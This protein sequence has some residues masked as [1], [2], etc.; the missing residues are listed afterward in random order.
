MGYAV[1]ALAR[2]GVSVLAQRSFDAF[3]FD[4]WSVVAYVAG[5]PGFQLAGATAFASVAM[6][7]RGAATGD[8]AHL[9]VAAL[10]GAVALY[11]NLPAVWRDGR[12]RAAPRPLARRHKSM[13]GRLPRAARRLG[14]VR[15]AVAGPRAASVSLH[16]HGDLGDRAPFALLAAF[17][18]CGGGGR[19]RRRRA[20]VGVSFFCVFS[21]VRYT[22]HLS[23]IVWL[24]SSVPSSHRS[25][26]DVP[27]LRVCASD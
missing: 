24:V 11:V 1:A 26:R 4:R 8:R 22:R 23:M 2:L 25:T 21:G 15:A 17:D 16:H 19:P 5:Q 9:R 13:R 6:A 7:V 12:R 20:A 18:H 10:L 27:L 14:H 3:F